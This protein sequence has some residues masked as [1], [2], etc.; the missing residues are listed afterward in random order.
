MMEDMGTR[1]LVLR[2][3]RGRC[4]GCGECIDVCP[5]TE[6]TEFPVYEAG[7]DGFPRVANEESC[8]GCLSCEQD[9]RADAISVEVEGREYRYGPVEVRAEIKSR[10]MF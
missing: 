7:E 8:I 9:C 5:Q 10:A 3:D 2:I 1:E 4:V 6:N